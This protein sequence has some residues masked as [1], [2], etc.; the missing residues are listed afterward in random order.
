MVQTEESQKEV[1]ISTLESASNSNSN[2]NSNSETE[3]LMYPKDELRKRIVTL[4]DTI[5]K[6][7]Y[8]T[9]KASK[10]VRTQLMEIVDI[11][12]NKYNMQTTDLR[13]LVYEIFRFRGV[14]DSW[15]RRLMPEGLKYTSKTRISYQQKQEIEK[16]RQRLLQKQASQS[17]QESEIKEY[18]LPDGSVAGSFSYQPIGLELKPSSSEDGQRLEIQNE[19]GNDLLL[20]GSPSSS[21]EYFRIQSELSA[22]NKKIE[23]LEDDVRRLSESFVAKTCIQA[24][25]RN[26]PLIVKIDPV[27]KVITW[28][29]FD[30]ATAI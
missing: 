20:G 21:K 29:R 12:S 13:N 27:E 3:D 22:A 23:R 14:S 18:D 26:I 9:V 4:A 1:Q 7:K 16:E 30:K 28:I 5:M 17:Q 6:W 11:G 25:T 2:S 24:R 19:L 15:I 8:V 10:S